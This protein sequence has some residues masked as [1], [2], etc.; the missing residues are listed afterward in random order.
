[1]KIGGSYTSPTSSVFSVH[2]DPL[3]DTTLPCCCLIFR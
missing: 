2:Q 3:A 1:M